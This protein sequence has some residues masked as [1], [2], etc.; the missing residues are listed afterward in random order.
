MNVFGD[1]PQWAIILLAFLAA[2]VLV[3]LNIGWLLQARG[4]LDQLK[5]RR[6]PGETAN[7]PGESNPHADG[8]RPGD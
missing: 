2:G 6:A 3:M 7:R 8:G 4:M 1:L 5:Q